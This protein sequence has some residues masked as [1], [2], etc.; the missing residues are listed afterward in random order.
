VQKR[1]LTVSFE[2]AVYAGVPNTIEITLTPL[3]VPTNPVSNTVLVGGPQTRVLLLANDINTITFS[4]V[5]SN[6]PDLSAPLPYRIA[7][8]E[9]Y[10]GTQHRVDFLMPNADTNFAD[11]QGVDQLS[12]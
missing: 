12:S 11:L 9:R 2:R 5:P 1:T 6:H 8:R 4:L 10:M 7:W 3:A